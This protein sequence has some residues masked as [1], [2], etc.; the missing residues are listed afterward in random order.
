MQWHAYS[1]NHGYCNICNIYPQ[2]HDEH[3]YH[4]VRDGYFIVIISN[5]AENGTFWILGTLNCC[6]MYT[7]VYCKISLIDFTLCD[8]TWKID[9]WVYVDVN[10]F[11]SEWFRIIWEDN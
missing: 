3:T 5:F 2:A 11:I 8:C 7:M 10:V 4:A 9:M 1:S 6:I